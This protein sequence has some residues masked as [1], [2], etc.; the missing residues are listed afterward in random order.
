MTLTGD[1]G[2][3]VGVPCTI[4]ESFDRPRQF[5]AAKV[6]I[7]DG[8]PDHGVFELRTST[9]SAPLF[10]ASPGREE[11]YDSGSWRGPRRPV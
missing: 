7:E 2:R 1:A 6:T 11:V 4:C 3:L 10:P 8:H 5:F 9:R